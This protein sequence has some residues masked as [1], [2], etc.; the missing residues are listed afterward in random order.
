MCICP[1]TLL[2]IKTVLFLSIFSA[3]LIA[4]L[5]VDGLSLGKANPNIQTILIVCMVITILMLVA[6]LVGCVATCVNHVVMLQLLV[7]SLM[8]FVIGK[9][10]L[11]I[12]A[13]HESPPDQRGLV[14]NIWFKAVLL[15]AAVA[16]IFVSLF[17]MRLVDEEHFG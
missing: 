1:T 8:G 10:V 5:C 11:W 12:V 9:L 13:S 6:C 14:T 16:T 2:K 3:L 4:E 15:G 7:F 17:C